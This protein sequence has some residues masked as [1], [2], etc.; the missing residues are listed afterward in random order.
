[1]GFISLFVQISI[2]KVKQYSRLHVASIAAL[3]ISEIFAAYIVGAQTLRQASERLAA[4]SKNISSGS[5]FR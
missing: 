5:A 4:L 3:V 1:M 2:F